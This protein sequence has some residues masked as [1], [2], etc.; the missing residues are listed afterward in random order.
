MTSVPS[1]LSLPKRDALY[2][3]YLKLYDPPKFTRNTEIEKEYNEYDK[4]RFLSYVGLFQGIIFALGATLLHFHPWTSSS[5]YAVTIAVSL[6]FSKIVFAIS[7]ISFLGVIYTSYKAH[8][9]YKNYKNLDER[10]KVVISRGAFLIFQGLKENTK[11]I[12]EGAII[13]M[14]LHQTIRA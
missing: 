13:N 1:S 14:P 3:A 10:D 11:K 12:Y 5:S 4:Y 8:K 9:N 7:I 2:V 6:V